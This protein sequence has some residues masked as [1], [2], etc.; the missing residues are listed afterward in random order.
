M[1]TH[2][3][4]LNSYY[5]NKMIEEAKKLKSLG[6]ALTILALMIILSQLFEMLEKRNLNRDIQVKTTTHYDTRS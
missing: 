5:Q 1:K 3:D 2:N 4:A 6:I